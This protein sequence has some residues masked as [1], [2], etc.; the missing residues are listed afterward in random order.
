MC[1]L[2]CRGGRKLRFLSDLIT[3]MV[4]PLYVLSAKIQR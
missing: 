4:V 3:L 1:V 2:M